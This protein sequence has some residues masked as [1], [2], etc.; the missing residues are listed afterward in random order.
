MDFPSTQGDSDQT[1]P[2]LQGDLDQTYPLHKRI[3]TSL[4]LYTRGSR[5]DLPSSA[6]GG[7]N[8]TYHIHR[9]IYR[10][11][12]KDKTF[13][14]HNGG[15]RLDFLTTQGDSDYSTLYFLITRKDSNLTYCLLDE[16]RAKLIQTRL[17][18]NQGTSK[19]TFCV[20]R[21]FRL[22]FNSE[23]FRLHAKTQ[24]RLSVSRE[25]DQT[26]CLNKETLV[27]PSSQGGF[28]LDFPS[29]LGDSDLTF[30]RVF[31]L[32]QIS[33]SHYSVYTKYTRSDS[34]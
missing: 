23:Q 12:Q 33:A 7:T 18:S 34:A 8:P 13:C 1:Y 16:I 27:N 31:F 11:R 22:D 2:L 29:T 20:T 30:H 19:Q 17:M 21:E 28:E 32:A 6:Q 14:L 15:F 10:Q 3:Q 5:L 25:S 4:T 9:G 26:S 24:S